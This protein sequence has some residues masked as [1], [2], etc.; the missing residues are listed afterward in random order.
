MLKKKRT[1]RVMMLVVRLGGIIYWK[2][3]C[4]EGVC[5]GRLMG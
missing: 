4:V 1:V 2:W 5:D 3:L